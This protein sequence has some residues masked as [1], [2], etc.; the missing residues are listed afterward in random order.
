MKKKCATLTVFIGLTM[1]LAIMQGGCAN[2]LA[3]ST[4]TKF[5]LDISQR[6]DQTVDVSMGYDRGEIASIPAPRNKP[7]MNNNS[8]QSD[9]Y[10]VLGSFMV[11]YDSPWD[12][13]PLVINQFFATGWAARKAATHQSMQ[14]FFGKEAG[15]IANKSKLPEGQ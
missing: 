13:K 14:E 12:D 9:A 11:S 2:I 5:G 6:A 1:P 15:E 7:A 8:E 3:F 4:A 10:S